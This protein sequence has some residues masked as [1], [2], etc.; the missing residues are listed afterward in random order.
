MIWLHQQGQ[1]IRL[2]V[3]RLIG[4]PV[5][6]LLSL[7]VI[8]IAAAL[9]AGGGWLLFNVAQLAPLVQASPQISVFMKVSADRK[10][11]KEVE[12]WA[13]QQAGVATVRLVPREETADRLRSAENLGDILDALPSNPF[14]DA[15]TL[16]LLT[17]ADDSPEQLEALATELRKLPKVEHVELDVTWVRRLN[18][19]LEIGR[20]GLALLSL[21]LGIG[22][23]AITFNTIRLQ[24]LFHQTEIELGRLL[25]ATD[26]FIRRPFVWF[27]ILQGGLGGFVAWLIVGATGLWLSEPLNALAKLYQLNLI[28]GSMGGVESLLL[29]GITALL[30]WM[31]ATLSI[32]QYLGDPR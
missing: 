9:P 20:T 28:T 5:G 19:L 29:V 2:A 3:L 17:A 21:L 24:L 18:A 11:A 22:L 10:S 32:R 30:G 26:A 13:T 6:T 12:A 14:P 25:G 8:G 16:T 1:A 4:A 15:L 7:I 31:G 27:G 23:I